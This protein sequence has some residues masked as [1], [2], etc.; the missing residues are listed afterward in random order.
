M[1]PMGQLKITMPDE[2]RAQLDQASAKSSLSVA[3]EIR[4]RVE[5]TFQEEAADPPTRELMDAVQKIA[6]LVKLQT[7][8]PWHEDDR[9]A[10]LFHHA[11]I[12]RLLRLYP[13]IGIDEK[14][15]DAELPPDRPIASDGTPDEQFGWPSAIEA[16]DFYARTQAQKRGA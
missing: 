12:H 13:N 14:F 6:E 7:G 10:T 5:R 16:I 8:R 15:S 2:L 3:E 11:I 1:S 9:A 4:S